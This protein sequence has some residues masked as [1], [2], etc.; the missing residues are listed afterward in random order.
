MKQAPAAAVS[1][2]TASPSASSTSA[3][4]QRLDTE[5]LPCFTTGTPQAAVRSAVPVEMLKLPEASPPV[6]TISIERRSGGN[7]GRRARRRIACAS[8]RSSCATSPLPESAASSAPAIAAGSCG[9]VRCE[10]RPSACSCDRSRRSMSCCSNSRGDMIASGAQAGTVFEEVGEHPWPFRGE[11]AFRV[12]LHALDGERAVSHGHDLALGGAR[13]HLEHRRY[14]R[15]S[16]DQGMVPSHLARLRHPGKERA[17]IVLHERGLAVHEPVGA[18]DLAAENLDDRLVT[19]TYPEHRNA[20][21][22]LADHVHRYAGVA[23]RPGPRRDAQVRRRERARL[24][25]RQSVVAMHLHFGA[26]HEERLDQVVG[27]GVV[28]VD[29]QQARVH[30]PS[31]ASSRARTMAALLAST[32]SCSLSGTLSATMPAPAW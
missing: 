26:E 17:R 7:S 29:E 21:G 13:A 23:R 4:P 27:E 11:D 32:S 15:G 1:S 12:K 24:R 30:R 18:H 5:R 19:E 6:P 2:G 3:L 28:V 16:G 25:W 10:S 20:S 14:A 9:S 31:S 8:P 22:E